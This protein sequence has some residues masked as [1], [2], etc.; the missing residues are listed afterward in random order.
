MKKTV[1]LVLSCLL[2]AGLFSGCNSEDK[3]YVPTGNGLTWDEDYTGNGNQQEET[4]SDQTLNLTFYPDKTMNPYTCTDYTNRALFALLYQSLFVVD[5]DYNPQ[6]QL[7]KQYSVSQDLKTYVF[8][9]EKATFTDGSVLTAQDVLASLEAARDNDYYAGR[10]Q[11]VKSMELTEDAGIRIV[12]SVDCENL[13]LLLDIPIVQ[14]AQVQL[15]RPLG[16]GPYYLDTHGTAPVLRKNTAWWCKADMVITAQAIALSGAENP[17]TIRNEFQYE[18]LS[19]VCADP[20]SDNYADY[21][22]D[23]ELWDC[24]N[25]LFLYLACN[26]ESPVFSN[27]N[28][29]SALTFAID[30][31]TIVERYYRGFARSATLPASPLFPYYSDVL[32]EKYAYDQ[33]AQFTKAVTD[34]SATG[35]TIVLLVN[36]ED[37]LR[38]RVAR[39][40][41]DMLTACGLTVQMS[42]LSS[43]AY[44]RALQKREYD[45][46]LGQTK[47]SPNMDLSGFF[48]TK[49]SMNYGKISDITLYNLCNLALANHGN[50]YSLH[51][52]VMDD[53]RLC[54]VLFRSYAVYAERGLL[55]GLTPARD[56][57]FFYSLGKTMEKALIKS[58]K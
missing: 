46:Y 17:A 9:V 30:R 24:E 47:L 49:G 2:L 18:N 1:A 36:K 54:P 7:C 37:S 40:I 23:Y 33:G 29:R 58:E 20:G 3:P 25:G 35:E 14:A 45:L 4:G 13:P 28:V 22:C 11:Q 55:T 38:L 10:F 8:Y 53:G 12:L 51:K 43:S 34:A 48:S 39:D 19:L 56:S 26:M 52:G 32:A 27:P 16:T 6:P 21:R 5:R 31:D 57:V 50:Y 41:G 44:K 42:E 15:D